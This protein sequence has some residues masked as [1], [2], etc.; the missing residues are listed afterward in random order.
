MI[1]TCPRCELRF[2][3]ESEL[4]QHMAL[5]HDAEPLER[6]TYR[7]SREVEPLY[8]RRERAQEQP[9]RYLVVANQ[10][11]GDT[12]LVERLKEL[13]AQGPATFHVVVPATHSARYVRS[14][15]APGG[16]DT[17][18]AD[19]HDE[20]GMAQ[21][22][23]RLRQAVEALR[24]AGVEVEGEVGVPDPFQAVENAVEHVQVDEVILSTLPRGLSRWLD[25]D[26]PRRIERRLGVP[27]KTLIR[28]GA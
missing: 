28:E 16:G 18:E 2:R 5:D 27:V 17:A 25:A 11:L 8:G 4:A 7:S 24:A 19:E 15:A 14:G 21:A 13:A 1:H 6:Y 10:T 20:V 26:L 22:R 23:F 12:H 3:S 9:R